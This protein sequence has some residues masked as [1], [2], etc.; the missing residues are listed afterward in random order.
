[1][2]RGGLFIFCLIGLFSLQ[3]QTIEEK[4][5]EMKSRGGG[6]V[7]KESLIAVNQELKK[8][9]GE[10]LLCYR[11][12]ESASFE[13]HEPLLKKNEGVKTVDCGS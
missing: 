7:V 11:E 3:A 10:L 9:R 1:M 13:N 12:V 6:E 4:M 5:T 2:K 8:L